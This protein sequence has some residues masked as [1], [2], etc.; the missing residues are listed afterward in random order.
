MTIAFADDPD[1]RLLARDRVVLKRLDCHPARSRAVDEGRVAGALA[2]IKAAVVTKMIAV[3]VLPHGN[4]NTLDPCWF[5]AVE[6]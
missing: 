6:W 5:E 2:E 4:G 1:D 3:E